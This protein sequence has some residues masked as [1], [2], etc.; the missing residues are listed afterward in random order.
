MSLLEGASKAIRASE[1]LGGVV[2]L[3]GGHVGGEGKREREE[4]RSGRREGGS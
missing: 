1:G 2:R 3:A 4:E